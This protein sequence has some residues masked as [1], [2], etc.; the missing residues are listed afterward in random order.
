MEKNYLVMIFKKQRNY[1]DKFLEQ[2]AQIDAEIQASSLSNNSESRKF[3]LPKI[4]LKKFSG[5]AKDYLTFGSQFQKI[6]DDRNIADEDK[7]Q[8]LLQAMEPKSKAERLVLSF[9]ATAANYPKTIEQL[10]ERFGREDLLVQIYV[11]DL[12]S[13]V[14]KNAVTGRA[15]TDLP[16][17]YDELEGKLR[18]LESLGRLKKNMGIFDPLSRKLLTRRSIDGMGKKQKSRLH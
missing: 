4:K 13:L 10:R 7:M 12:L 15:K 5:E 11:R 17:L 3:K 14:M 1:R 16:S 9:P 8:Y 18:A 2:C 6:H